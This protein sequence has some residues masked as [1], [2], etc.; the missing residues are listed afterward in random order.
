M[1]ADET[2]PT[3]EAVRSL[4]Y[5]GRRLAEMRRERDQY[6]DW[7]ERLFAAAWRDDG[8][9]RT[10]LQRVRA[11][12]ER[13]VNARTRKRQD[14]AAEKRA[15]A[16]RRYADGDLVKVIAADL[17]RS[18]RWVYDTIPKDMKRRR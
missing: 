12:H 9:L 11:E 16:I 2:I 4:E 13:V 6:Q 7:F 14:G 15:E 18:E 10:E 1:S 3:G 17:R 5:M 8:E